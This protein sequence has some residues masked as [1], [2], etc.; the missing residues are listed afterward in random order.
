VLIGR[1]NACEIRSYDISVSRMHA[2]I[3]WEETE[4]TWYIE[5]QNSKFGTL[6]ILN[7]NVNV[8]V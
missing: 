7:G 2:T 8:E 3:K 4:D 1:G 5:D 6:M